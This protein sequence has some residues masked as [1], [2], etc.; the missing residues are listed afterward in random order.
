M[1]K[2][3]I[4]RAISNLEIRT[5]IDLDTTNSMTMYPK[6]SKQALAKKINLLVIVDCIKSEMFICGNTINTRQI[7]I[8]K[9]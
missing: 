6:I 4:R 1:V 5:V 9:K 7:T 2:A 3:R 8:D